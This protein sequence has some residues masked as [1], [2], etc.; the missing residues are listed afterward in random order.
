MTAHTPIATKPMLQR[1]RGLLNISARQSSG[2]VSRLKNLRQQGSYRTIF[3]RS[4]SGNVEAV[5]INTAGGVTGGD[6]FSTTAVAHTGASL[7]ITT[8]AAERIYRAPDIAKGS[9]KTKLSVHENAQMFWVPQET[10][11]FEGARLERRLDVDLHAGAKFLMVEPLIFGR[12]A[13]GE[14]LRSG[15]LDDRVSIK[16]DAQPLYLDRIKLDGDI[17][18]QLGRTALA[19]GARAVANIVLVDPNAASFLDKVR[20]KLSSSAGASLL[21][22]KTLVV[23]ILAADSFALRTATLPILT[24]L[25]D[26]GVPKNWRL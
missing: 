5:I 11:L 10:I 25:T 3:P 22:D 9:M 26:D 21:N 6:Q 13:S 14:T 24:L 18:E 2:G 7:S 1:A 4:S 19:N 17:D 23:R 15:S 16:L 20:A 12:E 8:Q